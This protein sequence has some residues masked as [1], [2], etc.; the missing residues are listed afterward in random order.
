[1][2]TWDQQVMEDQLEKMDQKDLQVMQAP[3][4]LKDL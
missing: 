4:D 2:E 1:M 3:P